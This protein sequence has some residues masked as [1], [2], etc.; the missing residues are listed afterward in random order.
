ME[1]KSRLAITRRRRIVPREPRPLLAELMSSVDMPAWLDAEGI[2]EGTP[3][4]IG[5][6]GVYDVALNGYGLSTEMAGRP[7]NT[8]MAFARDVKGYLDFLWSHRPPVLEHSEQGVG[9]RP[10][11]W[12]DATVRDRE[13]YKTWRC[14]DPAGPRVEGSTWNREVSTVDGFYKWAVRR[15]YATTNPIGQREIRARSLGRHGAAGRAGQTAAEKRPDARRY[16]LDWLPPETYRLFRDVGI[17]GYLPSGLRD[18]KYRGKRTARNA[19]F[20]DLMVRTGLRLEEQSSLTVY[21]VPDRTGTRAYYRFWLPAAVAK[22]DSARDVYVPD[23]VLRALDDYVEIDRADAVGRARAAGRY[24]LVLDPIVL[25]DPQQPRVRAG[26]RW[27]D[28]EDLDPDE[29]RRLLIRTPQG[30]EP[31]ALWLGEDGLPLTLHTWK[32]VFREASHR[33]RNLGLKIHCHPHALRHSFAVITLEQLQRAHLKALGALT[34]EQRRHYTLIWGDTLDWVRIRLGH[35]SA[36]TTQI[37]LHT[38]KQLEMETRLSL[39]P[40]RWEVLDDSYL[41]DVDDALGGTAS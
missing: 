23:G 8:Q 6:D 20:A 33:C 35:A 22:W 14:D 32:Y 29:R 31:A 1:L 38:L 34:A 36:E 18:P 17:R 12:R 28:V 40:D 41:N 15:G 30:L 11:T 7:R 37:Y 4:L 16:R 25:E 21:E 2:A 27:R 3:F 24:E 19:V 26:S 5:P 13:V 10:R 39:V 9:A